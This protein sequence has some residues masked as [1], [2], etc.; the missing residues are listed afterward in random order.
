MFSHRV[1]GLFLFC[2]PAGA[3]VYALYHA[4]LRAA[5]VEW[6]PQAIGARMLPDREWPPADFTAVWTVL[7]SL[8]IGAASH[9]AW[10][11]FTHANTAVVH[12]ISIL[13]ASVTLG[14]R[15]VPLH[16]VLQH[17]S[18]LLGFLVLAAH[19]AAWFRRTEPVPPTGRRP[20]AR[21]RHLVLAALAAALVAGG[22]AGLLWRDAHSI[23]R[24]L[25]NVVTTGMAATAVA[26]LLL[27]LGWKIR[28][29]AASRRAAKSTG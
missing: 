20:G 8:L 18:S 14:A 11:A 12:H 7:V 13:R 19:A 29:R 5:F 24:V 22:T 6:A 26:I 3:L 28:Y 10:D 9:L 23:E 4:L 17:L 1:L 25:F 16:K 27:C 21:Q 15:V 2:V